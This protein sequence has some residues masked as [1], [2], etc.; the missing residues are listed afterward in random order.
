[1]PGVQV[2]VRL[3]LPNL[4]TTRRS[5]TIERCAPCSPAITRVVE[6]AELRA[7]FLTSTSTVSI[8]I[9]IRDAAISACAS[10]LSVRPTAA[11]IAWSKV[12]GSRR[13]RRVPYLV[14]QSSRIAASLL[15][16]A[17]RREPHVASQYEIHVAG[18]PCATISPDCVVVWCS[19]NVIG[20]CGGIERLLGPSLQ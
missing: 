7:I 18:Q 6:R 8:G 3:S 2:P 4:R 19:W 20:G 5:T 11:K 16:T 17:L 9:P 1:M 10:T 13:T 14:F 12:G 15:I